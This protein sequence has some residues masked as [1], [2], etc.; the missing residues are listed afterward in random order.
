MVKTKFDTNILSNKCRQKTIFKIE[1][2]IKNNIKFK[3]LQKLNP[4]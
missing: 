2:N 4:I 3:I 1:I